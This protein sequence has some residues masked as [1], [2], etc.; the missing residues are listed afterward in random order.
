MNEIDKILFNINI[1][2]QKFGD[3][4]VIAKFEQNVLNAKNPKLS[5]YFAKDIK[6]SNIKAHGKIIL[7]SKDPEY[8]YLFCSLYRW[9]RF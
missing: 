3:K 5:Y 1:I 6:K 4:I 9:C 2:K 8:N 7:D